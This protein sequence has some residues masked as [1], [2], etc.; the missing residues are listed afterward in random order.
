MLQ[1]KGRVHKRGKLWIGSKQYIYGNVSTTCGE[2]GKWYNIFMK[3]K[4]KKTKAKFGKVKR[5]TLK[6][7]FSTGVRKI[8]SGPN[9]GKFS[10]G[11]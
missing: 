4:N 2:N 3:K 1:I 11:W 5:V 9:K 10:I 8:L 6:S 7:G